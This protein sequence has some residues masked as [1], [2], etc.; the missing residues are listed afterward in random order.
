LWRKWLNSMAQRRPLLTLNKRK[1]TV[2]FKVSV[3]F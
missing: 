3:R 1:T 2:N